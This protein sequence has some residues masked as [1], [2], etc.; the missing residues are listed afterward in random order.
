MRVVKPQDISL[1][2]AGALL[3]AGPTTNPEGNRWASSV[4]RHAEEVA[5][6]HQ[7]PLGARYYFSDFSKTSVTLSIVCTSDGS[8]HAV[9]IIF[10]RES[11]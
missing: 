11:A 8:V 2:L 6:D 3:A 4:T 5:C 1:K 10:V 9:R 7:K